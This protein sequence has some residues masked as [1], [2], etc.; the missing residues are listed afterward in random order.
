MLI[1]KIQNT[2]SVYTT[3]MSSFTTAKTNEILKNLK[4]K[5]PTPFEYETLE[6]EEV[7]D[8]YNN[9]NRPLFLTYTESHGVV[10]I[11]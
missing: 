8:S 7:L 2:Y 9:E 11:A 3:K 5:L 6:L 10:V 1:H 4:A